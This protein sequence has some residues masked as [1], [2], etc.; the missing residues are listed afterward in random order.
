MKKYI[1]YALG[2]ILLVVIGILIA[3]QINNWNEAQK[4][5]RQAKKHLETIRLNLIDDIKQAEDLSAETQLTIDYAEV[6]LDQFKTFRPADEKIQMYIIYLMFERNIEV[7]NSGVTAL[8]NSNSMAFLEEPLQIKILNY[9]RYIE[10]LKSRELNANSEIKTMYE[11]YVK[12]NFYWIYNKTNPWH[13]QAELYKDDPRPVENL[14]QKLAGVLANK[15]FEIMVTHRRYQ[16]KILLDF[17][18]ETIR[19]AQEIISDIDQ[20]SS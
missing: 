7:D 4:S 5:T 8:L 2:E 6:F 16:T 3:L 14:D 17:Y 12:E 11:P 13:R 10:Q 18:T 15:R 20:Y 9:Y 1:K 19:L